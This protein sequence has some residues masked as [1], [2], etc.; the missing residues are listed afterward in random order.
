M[1]ANKRSGVLVCLSK[2]ML[3]FAAG[4]AAFSVTPG[5]GILLI[6]SRIY[7]W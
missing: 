1:T 4:K 2:T 7:L 6:L 5:T 3:G